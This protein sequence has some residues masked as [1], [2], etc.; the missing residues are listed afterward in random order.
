[1]AIPTKTKKMIANAGDKSAFSFHTKPNNLFT[2][3][4]G[5]NKQVIENLSKQKGEPQWMLDF[6]LKAY[7]IFLEKPMPNWGAD[8][9]GIDFD[10]IHYY[11][12]PQDKTKRDWKDVPEDIKNTFDKLGIP[13]AER[14]FLAGAG[15][16]FE[17]EMVYHS[18]A[19]DL[20]KQGVIFISTDDALKKYP[21]LFKQYFGTVVPPYDNKFASLNSAVWSGGS[22]IYV[23]KGVHIKLPLQAYFRINI[24]NMGQFERT[25]IIADEGS[26]VHYVEGCTAPTYSSDSL[27]SAVVEII[28]KKNARVQYTTIQNWSGNVYNLVTKRALANENS[29]M[30][31]LD[32]NLGSKVTMKYP[33]IILREPGAK[34]EIQSLA[35]ASSGQHQDAGGKVIHLAPNTSSTIISKSISKN[36]GQTTYRGLV[37]VA[38]GAKNVK[39]RVVCDAL[40]LDPESRSDTYP[41]MDIKEKDVAIAHEATVANIGEDEL[42]Y[43]MSRG[44]S[45][46]QAATLIVNGFA[47]PIIKQLPMEYAV[48]LNRLLTLE[49]TGSIG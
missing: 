28:V 46:E 6:R 4:K 16:Q 22:F 49:M 43:L 14:K 40:M 31:W 25:L 41:T 29:E 1:M 8:L 23:P 48:E 21:K 11:V 26:S 38:K 7:E 36:G 27:H 32:C 3:A 42:F 10:N 2:S 39:T 33:S 13:E 47:N 12:R 5:L 24:E 44:L 9:S 15:A 19:K 30:F 17:S 37:K 34:G 45:E 35:F 20:A 18:L